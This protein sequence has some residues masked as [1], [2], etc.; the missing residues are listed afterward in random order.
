MIAALGI[1]HGQFS[2]YNTTK[3]CWAGIN[4][5]FNLEVSGFYRS[6]AHGRS[7]NRTMTRSAAPNL[8]RLWK[9]GSVYVFSFW[10]NSA[11]PLLLIPVFTR[12]LGPSDYGV[13]AMWQVLLSF[14]VPIVGLSTNAA[15]N[16][17][18]FQKNSDPLQ[19][20][21]EMR[22]YI[23]SIFP[24]LA[25]S[26]F[27]VFIA[28]VL[29]YSLIARYLLPVS[30]IWILA[31]PVVAV[32][33][34]ICNITLAYVNAEMRAKVYAVLYNGQAF[35]ISLISLVLVVGVSRNWEGRVAGSI[36]GIPLMAGVSLLYLWHRG[37]LGGK[38]RKDLTRHAILFSLP[39]L[40]HV[41][42][43]MIRSV[44]DRI[45]LSQITNLSEIGLFSVALS[46]TGI[47][48]ILGNAAQQA[49]VPWLYA[50]LSVE[51][52]NR[53][54]IVKITYAAFAIIAG[55]GIVFAAVAPYAFGILLG[56]RF[57]GSAKFIWWLTGSAVLQGAYY[58][59]VPYIAYV[60]RNKYSSYISIVGLAVNL[61]L[62]FVL[63]HFF[64]VMGVAATN[65][66]TALY[67][68]VAVFLVA[69]YCMPMP[70]TS[71]FYRTAPALSSADNQ[72]GNSP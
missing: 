48:S 22:D 36:I 4:W 70:W 7:F 15:V 61:T 35:A 52:V 39:L 53:A 33:T 2:N 28:F 65:F 18:Y 54:L 51:N 69:N 63:S 59:L 20:Q 58:F 24:I 38:I 60:E 12:F 56:S 19:H 47:F 29:G 72:G 41:V 57:A 27:V 1:I 62:N 55:L 30:M 32:A 8:S 64:E 68:F 13:S 14:S 16:R 25:V 17:R 21:N 31:V 43:F 42:A 49:W 37:L 26:S 34:F 40:P 45:F 71:F 67:E 9:T 5:A 10:L 44:S 11:L 3:R 66:F 46:L 50:H 23:A 6:I